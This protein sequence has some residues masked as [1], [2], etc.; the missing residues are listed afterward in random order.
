[1]FLSIG[2]VSLISIQVIINLGVVVGL[3]PVTGITLPFISYGG[4]SVTILLFLIG[5]VIGCE[6]ESVD[7]DING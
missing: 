1:M 4:S 3:L 2:V 6:K 5:L 7:E